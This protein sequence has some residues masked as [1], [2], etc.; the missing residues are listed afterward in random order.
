[1][2][3]FWLLFSSGGWTEYVGRCQKTLSAGYQTLN[4]P[5]H[6]PHHPGLWSH[7]RPTTQWWRASSTTSSFNLSLC[8]TYS[9]HLMPVSFLLGA[10]REPWMIS[11]CYGRTCWSLLCLKTAAL[12]PNTSH[13]TGRGRSLFETAHLHGLC[14]KW[15]LS[16]KSAC[17]DCLW[18]ALKWSRLALYTTLKAFP[19]TSIM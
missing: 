11:H 3:S 4:C 18:K 9:S 17:C 1:M 6:P 13:E 12:N 2:S 15:P 14:P 8:W 16:A 10:Q 7:L 19:E 5:S